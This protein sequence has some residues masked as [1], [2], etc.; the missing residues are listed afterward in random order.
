MERRKYMGDIVVDRDIQIKEVANVV[1]NWKT[2][3]LIQMG[4]K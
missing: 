3:D 1:R 2:K 4:N